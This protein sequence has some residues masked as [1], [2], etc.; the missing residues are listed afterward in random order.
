MDPLSELAR[1]YGT[2]KGG[3]HVPYGDVNHCCHVYTPVYWEL[4]KDLREKPINFLEI[5]VS[6]G[7]SIRMWREFFPYAKIFGWDN[8]I[9]RFEGPLPAGVLLQ[10]V[11][12]SDTASLLGTWRDAGSPSFDIVI[13]DGSHVFDHQVTTFNTL[14]TM[15]T[16]D[17]IYVI[18]DQTHPITD[19]LPAM[20]SLDVRQWP[21]PRDMMQIIR[22]RWL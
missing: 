21:D 20:F 8:A 9:H 1:K 15:L 2:D 18:E 17:G 14:W 19:K 12:Q 13:D 3:E 16:R 5:G 11:D 22:H 7:Y 4:F 6:E 10:G